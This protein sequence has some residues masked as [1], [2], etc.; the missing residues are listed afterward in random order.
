MAT[1][2]AHRGRAVCVS[3]NPGRGGSGLMGA[4]ALTHVVEAR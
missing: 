3:F 1:P 2:A 4:G